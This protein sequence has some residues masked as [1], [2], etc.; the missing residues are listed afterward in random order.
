M[1]KVYYKSKLYVATAATIVLIALFAGSTIVAAQ[2]IGQHP[3]AVKGA[4]VE[5]HEGLTIAASPWTNA[6]L[7]KDKFGKNSPLKAGIVAIHLSFRN[8]SNQA[9]KV[10]ADKIQL[11][12]R[13]SDESRQNLDTLTPEDVADAIRN[14]GAR[15]ITAKRKPIPGGKGWRDK[16]WDEIVQATQ[17]A[18]LP[19]QL[20]APHS[21]MQGLVFFDLRGQMDLLDTA[22]LYIP[23]LTT[24]ETN[25]S[26]LYFEIDLGWHPAN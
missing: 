6:D 26:L 3:A 21:T 24:L 7:Y 17:N 9:I 20:I 2:Q 8:D 11:Q 18:A 23:D 12:V 14:P 1:M 5:S 19:T 16:H 10:N 25:H 22:H 13:L 4:R 15:D